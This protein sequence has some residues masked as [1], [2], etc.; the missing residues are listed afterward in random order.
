MFLKHPIL[1]ALT[2]AYLGLVGWITLGPQPIDTDGDAWLWSLLRFF[3]RHDATSW[4]TYQRVEFLAN[5]A[6]FLP[7]GI[8]FLLLLGRRLWFVSVLMG[9]GLTASI[10]F[11]QLFIPGRVSD[12]RDIISNSLGA[13]LGVL[14]ALVLTTRSRGSVQRLRTRSSA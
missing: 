3:G 6:M 7:V 2:L 11:A 9:V 8:F 12:F 10:E 4:L 1:S 13:I 14:I 5:V